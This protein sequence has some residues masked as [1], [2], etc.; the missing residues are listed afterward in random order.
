MPEVDAEGPTSLTKPVLRAGRP[1]VCFLVLRSSY[2]PKRTSW[3]AECV[4]CWL[5]LSQTSSTNI[6][7]RLDVRRMQDASGS[8]F[9]CS[10]ELG[11]GA[12]VPQPVSCECSAGRKRGRGLRRSLIVGRKGKIEHASE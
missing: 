1:A 4:P 11:D 9:D 8:Q 5:G 3:T 2:L 12:Y 10:E 6:L 7:H